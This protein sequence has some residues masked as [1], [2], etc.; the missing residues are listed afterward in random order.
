MKYNYYLANTSCFSVPLEQPIRNKWIKAIEQFQKFDH[1]D[2][3]FNVCCLHF[4]SGDINV[5]KNKKSVIYGRVPTIF[6]DIHD[7]LNPSNQINNESEE[8]TQNAD[9]TRSNCEPFDENTFAMPFSETD[10]DMVDVT[11]VDE[12]FERSSLNIPCLSDE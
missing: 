9:S 8:V 1:D 5:G 7:T 12:Q 2:K 6:P 4:S 10:F 3:S 11:S